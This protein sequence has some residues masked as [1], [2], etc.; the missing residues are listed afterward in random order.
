MNII[1]FSF[2]I[3]KKNLGFSFPFPPPKAA[4]WQVATYF[5]EKKIPNSFFIADVCFKGAVFPH[6]LPLLPRI[7]HRLFWYLRAFILLWLPKYR[8]KYC[9]L[10]QKHLP[11]SHGDLAAPCLPTACGKLPTPFSERVVLSWPISLHRPVG[12]NAAVPGAEN[13]L[14]PP[15]PPHS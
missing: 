7:N 10:P 9:F 15:L 8:C 13:R 1:Q 11:R 3:G 12:K 4:E 6:L 14:A 2:G 5:W